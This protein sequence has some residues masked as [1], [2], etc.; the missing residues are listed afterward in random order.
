MLNEQ[1]LS[2]DK[3]QQ[4]K[5]NMNF[6]KQ[7]IIKEVR[8]NFLDRKYITPSVK[9]SRP[10]RWVLQ[11]KQGDDPQDAQEANKGRC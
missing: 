11:L 3:Q 6:V 7:M 5:S 8:Q 4:I 10:I 9:D 2:V 1:G